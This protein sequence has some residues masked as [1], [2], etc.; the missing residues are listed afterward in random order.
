[1]SISVHQTC[2]RASLHKTQC[3]LFL[4]LDLGTMYVWTQERKL[5]EAIAESGEIR[6]QL[7]RMRAE[8]ML[9][10]TSVEEVS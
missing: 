7:E 5:A 6:G 3:P 9:D 8:R 4:S 10:R 1:M 2:A